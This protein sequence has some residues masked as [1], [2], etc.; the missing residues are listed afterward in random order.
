MKIINQ[1]GC[2]KFALV[3]DSN[4]NDKAKPYDL[5]PRLRFS[6]RLR[7]ASACSEGTNTWS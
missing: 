1:F 7:A 2:M 4:I 3:R 6:K 5:A